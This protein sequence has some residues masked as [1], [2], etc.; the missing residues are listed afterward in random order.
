MA[1]MKV[2]VLAHRYYLNRGNESLSIVY[3]FMIPF[4]DIGSICV[5]R[6]R[7][8]RTWGPRGS[9]RATPDFAPLTGGVD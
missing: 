2:R 5:I 8:L 4:R 1:D 3:V 9:G 6:T 7:M